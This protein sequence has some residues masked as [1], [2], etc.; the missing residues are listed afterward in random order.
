[1][2]ALLRRWPI[3]LLA[4]ILL[5]A[6]LLQSSHNARH[7][8][9]RRPAPA[10]T[11]TTTPRIV[12][13]S[14]TTRNPPTGHR[15]APAAAVAG[16][17]ARAYL[18]FL[19]GQ[20]T[21]AQLPAATP[22]ARRQAARGGQIPPRDRAGALT[23]SAIQRVAPHG[24]AAGEFVFVAH[25]HA[26]CSYP[27]QITIARINRRWRVTGLVPP[28][29]DTI[30]ALHPSPPPRSSIRPRRLHPRRRSRPALAPPRTGS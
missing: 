21:A 14:A 13:P 29:L 24:Q 26:P 3:L 15:A 16:A 6:V 17:F 7:A 11:A 19:D 30:L 8:R 9:A 12:T 10:S 28:E 23:L 1:M 5:A 25:D 20:I 2:K 18:R 4:T 27:A 22:R